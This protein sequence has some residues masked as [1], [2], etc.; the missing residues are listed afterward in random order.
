VVNDYRV[1]RHACWAV[2]HGVVH[3]RATPI[4]ADAASGSSAGCRDRPST[5]RFVGFFRP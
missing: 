5:A 2:R 4:V 1:F 3:A